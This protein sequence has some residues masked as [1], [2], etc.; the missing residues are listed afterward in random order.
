MR[1]FIVN[2]AH[3][4]EARQ[5]MQT[6]LDRLGL[7][8]EFFSAI[9]GTLLTKDALTQ[10]VHDY[11]HAALTKGEIGCAL[12]HLNI[13]KKMIAED[14]PYALILEDDVIL[15]DALLQ[16]IKLFE[17]NPQTD[18]ASYQLNTVD[19]YLKPFSQKLSNQYSI[20]MA[21]SGHGTFSYIINLEGAKRLLAAQQPLR[22]EADRWKYFQ[23]LKILKFKV[24][25][26]AT[27]SLRAEDYSL[28][29]L[30][31]ERLLIEAKRKTYFDETVKN[32]RPLLT[33]LKWGIIKVVTRPFIH[34][35]KNN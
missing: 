29:N 10:L 32:K 19:R 15:D 35:M 11:D 7:K 5:F 24:I 28:S 25:V 14:L 20:H 26:P 9:N 17:E 18:A 16:V 6:Q 21:T 27:V 33:R 23:Q 3:A 30:H 31:Q 4:T 22:F 34:K 1:I 2:L 13:Y 8:A 12:S